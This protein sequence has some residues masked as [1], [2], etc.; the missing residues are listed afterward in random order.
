MDI[1]KG[2]RKEGEEGNCI[3]MDT[4]GC[5]INVRRTFINFQV[6]SQ[7]YALIWDRTFIEFEPTMSEVNVCKYSDKFVKVFS[8]PLNRKVDK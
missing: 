6:F 4:L 1:I 8:I 2:L 5:Q 3:F 7:P